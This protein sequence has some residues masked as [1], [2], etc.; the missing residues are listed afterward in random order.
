MREVWQLIW[1]TSPRLVIINVLLMVVSSVL[2]LAVLWSIGGLVDGTL[3]VFREGGENFS[4]RPVVAWLIVFGA[5]LFLSS[6]CGTLSGQYST[7]LGES[8]RRTVSQLVHNQ[9]ERLSYQTVQ[10]PRFQNDSF[11]TVSGSTERPVR[12]FFSAQT[13]IQS[14]LT[15]LSLAIWLAR[16]AW[17]LPFAVVAA[18]VPIMVARLWVS[19]QSYELYKRLSEDE[20]RIR[21]YNRVLTDP[22]YLPESRMFGMETFFRTLF[23]RGLSSLSYARISLARRSTKYEILAALLSVVLS[24]AVFLIVIMMVAVGGLSVGSLAMYLMAVRRA[25]VAV[26]GVARHGVG[27]HSQLLYIRSFFDFLTMKDYEAGEES[28][29]K[30]FGEIAFSGVSFSYPGSERQAVS[31]LTFTVK[32]GEVVGLVGANGS[33]KSTV[34]KLLCGLLRPTSGTVKIGGVEVCNI[35]RDEFTRH[36]SVLFQ[37]FRIYNV[38]ARENIWFGYTPKPAVDERIR[39]AAIR[40]D[41]DDLLSNL[42]QGYYTKL[43]NQFEGSEMFSRGE[44]QRMALA[45]VLYSRAEI[46]IL[47]EPASSLDSAARQ[48]LKRAVEEMKRE[49]KTVIIVSH[50]AETLAVVDRVVEL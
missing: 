5:T 2:P 49:G 45:R 17:W 46:V 11:R 41:L 10:S 21:Y 34:V 47:D 35:Y 44:W 39:E 16:V 25:D 15:F 24:V 50:I 31:G 32:R 22:T 28:F 26:Q 29:P 33:G 30:E 43:G 42:P 38:S 27:L 19:R 36:V 37:D 7:E 4:L 23:G 12:I 40:T 18:G 14:T 13:L 1:R 48:V 9:V 3:D 20:R 6:V 8:L